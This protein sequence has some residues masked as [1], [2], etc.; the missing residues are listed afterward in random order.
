MEKADLRM[1]L[2][3]DKSGTRRSEIDHGRF[4]DAFLGSRPS[5]YPECMVRRFAASEM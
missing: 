4:S 5:G 1:D 2:T 3:P